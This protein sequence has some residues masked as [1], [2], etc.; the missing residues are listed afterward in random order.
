M[1]SPGTGGLKWQFLGKTEEAFSPGWKSSIAL[2]LGGSSTENKVLP[3]E[4]SSSTTYVTGSNDLSVMDF[5]WH[6]GYR[7]PVRLLLYLNVNWSTYTN[8]ITVSQTNA[9]VVTS[10]SKKPKSENLGLILGLEYYFKS[11]ESF[12]IGELGWSQGKVDSNDAQ[13]SI[14]S[15]GINFGWRFE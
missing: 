8:D 7:F 1:Q 15:L 6:I 4:G 13:N 9:G 12:L 2:G 11:K 10:Y 14:A 5:N 3:I